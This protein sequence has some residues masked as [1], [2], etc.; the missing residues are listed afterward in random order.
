ML[1]K[2]HDALLANDD[3]LSFD[4]DVSKVIYFSDEIGILGVDLDRINLDDDHNFYEDDPE[5]IIHVNYY[6]C[7][8]FGLAYVG[9]TQSI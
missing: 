9:K 5:T 8:A 2:F 7:Q 1:E 6:S 4:E 3:I